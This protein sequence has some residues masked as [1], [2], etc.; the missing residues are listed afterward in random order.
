M[1]RWLLIPLLAAA[2]ALAGDLLLKVSKVKDSTGQV[3][4]LLFATEDGFP[5]EAGKAAYQGRVNARK[6]MTEL[7]LHDV[8]PGRYA[9]SVIHDSNS[10]ALLDR[11]LIGIP[12]EGAGTSNGTQRGKPV[13]HK[14]VVNVSEG[15]SVSVDLN[16][17]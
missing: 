5:G 8:K 9:V 1:V 7:V 11:N 3:S 6:G 17:W 13:Y 10:N 14:A 4:V 12:T 15:G 16:Y 2:P